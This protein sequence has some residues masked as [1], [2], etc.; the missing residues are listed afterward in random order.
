MRKARPVAGAGLIVSAPV[1]PTQTVVDAA[2]KLSGLSCA[3]PDSAAVSR[4]AG[5]L[6]AGAAIRMKLVSLAASGVIS[7]SASS[8]VARL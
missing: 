8:S 3:A 1:P 4:S 6:P 5:A 2:L 7:T